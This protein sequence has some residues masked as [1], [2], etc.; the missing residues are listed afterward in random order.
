MKY[1]YYITNSVHIFI[2]I[3]IVLISQHYYK[4]VEKLKMQV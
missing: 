4:I 2:Q 3:K 1:I